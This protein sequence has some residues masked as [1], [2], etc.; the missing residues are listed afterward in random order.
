M[1]DS[2]EAVVLETDSKD[3]AEIFGKILAADWRYWGHDLDATP[4]GDMTVAVNELHL[5]K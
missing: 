4:M 2:I 1:T 5:D 3:A